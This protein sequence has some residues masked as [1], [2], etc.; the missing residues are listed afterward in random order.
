MANGQ[1]LAWSIADYLKTLE[2]KLD[3]LVAVQAPATP[4]PA[5]PAPA[6][7]APATPT[8]AAPAPAA[9]A[10]ATPTPAAPAPVALAS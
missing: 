1:K 5:A 6:A 10:P 9:Q 8:P 7:Q 2:Q 4:T 3:A